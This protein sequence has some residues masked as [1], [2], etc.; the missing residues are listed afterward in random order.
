MRR[1][2]GRLVSKRTSQSSGYLN[3]REYCQL[4]D[5]K[6]KLCYGVGVTSC[7]Y[8]CASVSA[9]VLDARQQQQQQQHQRIGQFS[10]PNIMVEWTSEALD[11]VTI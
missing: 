7:V 3:E 5:K 11:S 10:R 8:V 1:E 6:V 4:I 9:S 2:L